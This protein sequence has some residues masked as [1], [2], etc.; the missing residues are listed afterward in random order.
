M[1]KFPK[2]ILFFSYL[3]V[4]KSKIIKKL[5]FLYRYVNIFLVVFQAFTLIFFVVAVWMIY[6]Q[7]LFLDI[8]N[9]TLMSS[10]KFI[11]I[12]K[13]KSLCF[14][15]YFLINFRC[16]YSKSTHNF[17]LTLGIE[18]LIFNIDANVIVLYVKI[19]HVSFTLRC[20]W[21]SFRNRHFWHIKVSRDDLGVSKE[22]LSGLERT[23][24]LHPT[25]CIG[26]PNVHSFHGQM[27]NIITD[28][29]DNWPNLFSS[30]EPH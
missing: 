7:I 24:I 13:F 23:N 17:N 26:N 19:R 18:L 29:Q 5:I 30:Q 20:S 27:P 14:V 15:Y 16:I 4:S 25:G 21:R 28:Y 6:S 12:A 8:N 3:N 22:R 9:F 1:Y 11:D 10:Q 2:L